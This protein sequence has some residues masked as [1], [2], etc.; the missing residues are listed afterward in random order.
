M[1]HHKDNLREEFIENFGY[2]DFKGSEKSIWN[3]RARMK[4]ITDWWLENTIPTASLQALV[5][6]IEEMKKPMLDYA[7]VQLL[8]RH[9]REAY[10]EEVIGFNQALSLCK[11][12][13]LT[14]LKENE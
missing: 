13:L 9:E 1:T 12:L 5:E 10:G 4:W 3:D 14:C 6:K 7:E 11:D 8:S 2:Q